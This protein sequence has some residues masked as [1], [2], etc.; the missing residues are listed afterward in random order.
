[1]EKSK[2]LLQIQSLIDSQNI[3]CV[4]CHN[5]MKVEDEI[6]ASPI[7][8][9]EKNKVSGDEETQ[10][11]DEEF[12]T[13]LEYGMPPAAGLAISIDR[14]TMILSNTKNIREVILFPTLKPRD[15]DSRGMNPSSRTELATGHSADKR[16]NNQ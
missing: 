12:V 7:W 4:V 15:V 5:N 11:N 13:A 8:E 16:G 2:L 1:M 3:E 9:Q 10:P 14:L 6:F